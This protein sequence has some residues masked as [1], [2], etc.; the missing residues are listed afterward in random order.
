MKA[1]DNREF[2]VT[3]VTSDSGA[4]VAK[5]FGITLQ[6]VTYKANYL[7]KKG[8]QLPKLKRSVEG[9]GLEVAQLNSL[10]RKQ[11]AKRKREL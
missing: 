9:G 5:A 2:V 7:R 3:Y 6:Q 10:I 8:V 11:L 4:D 1:I